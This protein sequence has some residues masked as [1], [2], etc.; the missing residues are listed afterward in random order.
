MRKKSLDS[1][2]AGFTVGAAAS[3]GPPRGYKSVG[4]W[5]GGGGCRAR[6]AGTMTKKRQHAKGRTAINVGFTQTKVY[7][8]R[9]ERVWVG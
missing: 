7:T 1:S 6:K 2:G 4:R 3:G 8:A 5:V 9:K